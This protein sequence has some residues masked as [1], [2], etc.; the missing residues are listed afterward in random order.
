MLL[1]L[2]EP[3]GT[4]PSEH[5]DLNNAYNILGAD[6][7][8]DDEVLQ[9][10]YEV[11]LGDDPGRTNEFKEALSLVARDRDSVH[12]NSYL[13]GKENWQ[14]PSK[15][16]QRLN[17]PR[18]LNNIGNTCYL[19]SLLQYLYTI[20]PLREMVCNF[21]EYKQDI[22]DTQ[23]ILAK[24]IGQEKVTIAGVKRAQECEL[25]EAARSVLD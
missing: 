15:P 24:Q 18:G 10:S 19:N 8:V 25:R 17:E 1:H 21:D 22:D 6:P 20:K 12:L 5:M 23:G 7:S 3:S 9:S 2:V 11:L 14:A 4:G 13:R 16:P